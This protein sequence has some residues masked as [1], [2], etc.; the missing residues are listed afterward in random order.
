MDKVEE[1]ISRRWRQND[2][3][4]LTGNCYWFSRILCAQFPYLK[5]YYDPVQGHFF[6]G[7]SLLDKYYDASGAIRLPENV[8]TLGDIM[9]SDPKWFARLMRDCKD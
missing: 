8:Y 9:E 5:I 2:A 4:W 1:F 3:N 7:S 6:A